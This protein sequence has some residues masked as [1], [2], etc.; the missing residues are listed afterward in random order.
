MSVISDRGAPGRAPGSE[1][2]LGKWGCIDEGAS[3]CDFKL[4]GSDDC[5]RKSDSRSV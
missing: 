2:C 5:R 3:N 4:T 1:C